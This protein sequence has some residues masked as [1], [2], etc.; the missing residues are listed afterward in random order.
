MIITVETLM[1]GVRRGTQQVACSRWLGLP[2]SQ[3]LLEYEVVGVKKSRSSGCVFKDPAVVNCMCQL[4]WA[5]VPGSLVKPYSGGFC[6]GVYG[7]NKSQFGG[8][9]VKQ[10]A[11]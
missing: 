3:T 1:R 10:T 8:V 5:T 11:L 7:R 2:R 4:D 6:E 9:W